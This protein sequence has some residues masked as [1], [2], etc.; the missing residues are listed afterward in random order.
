M[1]IIVSREGN[2]CVLHLRGAMVA[3]SERNRIFERLDALTQEER[4]LAVNL[5]KLGYATSQLLGR[6]LI[7]HKTVA[8]KKG[9]FLLL[10]PSPGIR[11]LLRITGL[12][13]VFQ[14][15]NS[16]PK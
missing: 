7:A 16:L 2:F 10:S 15:H 1:E 9:K 13:R 11:D 3:E 8:Q 12:G 6:F 5:S 14:I 4:N